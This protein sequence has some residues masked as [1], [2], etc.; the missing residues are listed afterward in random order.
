M[1]LI[2]N[3][4]LYLG[5]LLYLPKLIFQARYRQNLLERLGF[6][7]DFTLDKVIWLHCVSVGETQAARPLVK[8]LRKQFPN[9]KLVISTTTPTGQ[10]LAKRVFSKDAEKIFYFPFDFRFSVRRVLKKLK[11]EVILLM[12][13]EIWF[14]FIYEASK[15][16]VKVC[17]VNARLSEKSLERYKL[18]KNFLR[19]ILE[20]VELILAQS[21]TDA[22]RFRTLGIQT[23]KVKITGN[24][25]FDHPTD[26]LEKDLTEYFRRRFNTGSKVILAASTHEPE[27]KWILKTFK[28]L[29]ERHPNLRLI[30]APRHPERFDKVAEMINLFGYGFSRRSNPESEDDKTCRIIL[31]DSIGELR[32]LMPLAEIIFVGGSLIPHGGQN[33]LEAAIHRKPVVTGFYTMNFESIIKQFVENNAIIQ[34]PK[35]TKENEIIETLVLTFEKILSDETLK[36]SLAENAFSTLKSSKGASARTVKL[37]AQLLAS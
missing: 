30:I 1:F 3:F 29:S 32:A 15:E 20:K 27:E 18:I 8:A 25:K 36:H 12:E 9:H 21:E 7:E 13:T 34:L 14:N 22:E 16:G 33:V 19:K 5:F 26:E 2:Y 35:L 31:I 4:L 24:L 11:P 28:I 10:E 23:S 6:L 37:L 17:I